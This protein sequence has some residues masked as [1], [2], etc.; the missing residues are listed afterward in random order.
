MIEQHILEEVCEGLQDMMTKFQSDEQFSDEEKYEITK[1]AYAALRRVILM[2]TIKGDVAN[3]A[4]VRHG[5]RIGW[6]VTT[7]DQNSKSYIFKIK[8][9]L[10]VEYKKTKGDLKAEEI[11]RILSDGTYQELV[12]DFY[13]KM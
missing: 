6:L 13:L 8:R 1:G 10:K 11:T 9:R 4:A 3:I 12:K 2:I 7:D 5:D